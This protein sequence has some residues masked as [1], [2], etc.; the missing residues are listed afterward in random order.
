MLEASSAS[1]LSTP[2]EIVSNDDL[3]LD[4][5]VEPVMSPSPKISTFG[6]GSDLTDLF[7]LSDE[8]ESEEDRSGFSF[9]QIGLC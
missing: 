6:G 1:T 5:Q 3:P 4:V 2:V 9:P 7:D 8:N